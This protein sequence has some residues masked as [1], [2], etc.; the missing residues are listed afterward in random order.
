MVVILGRHE[1][2]NTWLTL[3]LLEAAWREIEGSL[4]GLE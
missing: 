4:E 3:T 2:G 1:G